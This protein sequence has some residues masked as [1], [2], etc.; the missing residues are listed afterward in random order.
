MVS[1]MDNEVQDSSDV[2]TESKTSWQAHFASWVAIF[3]GCG[4]FGGLGELFISADDGRAGNVLRLLGFALAV[5]VA[6]IELTG[7]SGKLKWP[8]RVGAGA[9]VLVATCYF[10]PKFL[11][12][13]SDNLLIGGDDPSPPIHISK[14]ARPPNSPDS[15][16]YAASDETVVWLGPVVVST[17]ASRFTI[18]NLYG[19]DVLSVKV[20]NGVARIDA[21]FWDR[22]RRLVA[23]IEDNHYRANQNNTLPPLRPDRHTLIVQNERKG[24]VLHFRFLNPKCI[25]IT[26]T[27]RSDGPYPV[28]VKDDHIAFGPL[29]ISNGI[30]LHIQG[31][32]LFE[33]PGS[34]TNKLYSGGDA[35]IPKGRA[36]VGIGEHDGAMVAMLKT[37]SGEEFSVMQ[38]G[39]KSTSKTGE[40]WTSFAMIH[41]DYHPELDDH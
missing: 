12:D 22:D 9:V 6:A 28:I 15:A 34:I 27:F 41:R 4:L 16:W 2:I 3:V 1:N 38:L 37:S 14:D 35:V 5:I 24:T 33:W 26:G 19:K 7:K 31:S 17:K 39:G 40:V 20:T 32:T 18:V 23:T 13:K 21:D 36:F 25:K 10:L 8:V 11:E 29:V 30:A